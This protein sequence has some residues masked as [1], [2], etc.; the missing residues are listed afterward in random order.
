MSIW[1]SPVFYF[2]ILLMCVVV[3][4]LAAP[5]VVPW[6]NY[7]AD[8][9]SYG[10]KL[11]GRDVAIAGNIAVSLF[12]WPR[13]EAHHVAIGNPDGFSEDAF[14]QADVVRVSLSLGGLF[15]GTVNVE[16]VEV[17]RPQVNLQRNAAGNVN[18]ILVPQAK[19]TGEG[20][21][22]RVKLDQI[23][24][25]D[26][27]VSFDDLHNGRSMVFTDL[28]A[29]LSA[30]SVLGPWRMQGEAKWK[31][32][33]FELVVTTNAKEASSPL[34]FTVRLSPADTSLPLASVEG[35][36]D[37]AEF[38]GAARLDPQLATGEKSSVEGAF[39]PLAMQAAL[40]ASTDR[41]SLLKIRIAPSDRK[42]SGTLIEGDAIVEFGT[43]SH[44][45]VNLQSP[46]INMDTLV[47]STAMQQWRD[48]GFLKL[49]N[50]LLAR[51]PPTLVTDFSANVSVVTSGGQVLN[52]VRLTGTMQK[53][54][55]RVQQFA[56]QL[57]GRSLG[58]FDGVVF[59]G[60]DAAQL[61]GT[62]KFQSGDSRALLS[63]LDPDLKA[64]IEQHWKGS[65]G[66]LD[67]QSGRLD[68]SA[69]RFGISDVLYAF[70]GS[71][72]KAA[73]SSSFGAAPVLAVTIDAGQV[74]IDSLVTNGWSLTRDGGLQSILNF[75][76]QDWNAGT[77]ERRV[78]V[79]AE[80]LLLNGV[81]AQQVAIN[82]VSKASGFEISSLDI[83]NVNGAKL[84]GE[85]QMLDKGNGPEGTLNFQLDAQ[86]PRGFLQL[87]GFNHRAGK[88][89]QALGATHVNAKL[90]AGPGNNGPE[91]GLTLRGSS[92][93]L[94]AEIV[95]NARQ[96]EKGRNATVAV[97]GGLNSADS[98]AIARL[99]GVVP[100]AAAGPGDV[101]FEFNGSLDQGFLG[102]TK[103]KALDVVADFSGTM[104][105][106]QPYFGVTGRI[107]AQ[108]QDGRAFVAAV[109]APISTAPQQPLD[110]SA[111]VSVKD[112]ALSFL[113]LTGHIAGHRF[114]GVAGA[115]AEG[116]LQADL[117]TDLLDARE[118]M[119]LAFL[120]WE[121]PVTELAQGFA[122]SDEEGPSGDIFIKP[123]QFETFTSTA[124]TEV[125][126]AIGFE[127]A[128][129]QLSITAAGEQALKFDAALT[130]LGS[131][132]EFSGTLRWPFDLSRLL[133]T[134][135]GA[136]LVKGNVIAEGDFKSTGS[137]PSAALAAAEGKGHFWLSDAALSRLTLEGYA[138]AVLAAKTPEA[139]SQAFAKLGAGPGSHIGQRIGNYMITNGAVE[140]SAIPTTA[141]G[142]T[143]TI[144]PQ[145]DLTSGQIKIA[146]AL[147]LSAQPELPAVNIT[148]SGTTGNMELRN[149]T[150][151][152]A[153]KLGYDLLSKE[154][155]NLE[156]LQ[157]EQQALAAKEDAQ[158]KDDEQRFA[159]YQATKAE[160]RQQTRIRRFQ[161]A[162]QEK[163]TAALQ[164][165]SDAAIKSGAATSKI[166]LLRHARRLEIRRSVLAAPRQP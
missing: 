15:S 118:A 16:S 7:R 30:Q 92:G 49:T 46:R 35:A 154:M 107:S 158:R 53:E 47:G 51:L 109:G 148:Y 139:L 2:G 32:R 96:L 80:S 5:F 152:L 44:A 104:D 141:E 77:I 100:A 68:W 82:L 126:V 165:M 29:R 64:G 12:P 13:L 131:G 65:R 18:W 113:D 24:L 36:W 88:W 116:R 81:T 37:G 147:S 76:A 162:E 110:M 25:S 38:K 33:P 91:L 3:A 8:L 123:L 101:T 50:Q 130:P 153:A 4:A 129:R 95:L 155:A 78:N 14:V 85:G 89:T 156:Q 149:G 28:N 84:H 142:V 127:K 103:V 63:W 164:A 93:T 22:A 66:R 41:I 67:I 56:A 79:K 97:S 31:D 45:R 122:A 135:D 112:G 143:G 99:F 19:V 26:G 17:E 21:L 134:K 121:G 98:A 146:T 57:P 115:T 43:Q 72:G 133:M 27:L 6:N 48:G 55:I 73:V 54:A 94:N 124:L 58:V 102:S 39:K 86:D 52:D 87:A 160:L 20:L 105:V 62:F 111:V 151:A 34:K 132:H 125:V 90:S 144:V 61:G 106:K 108:S 60:K 1:R 163:R 140:F 136:A 83:G 128:K 10:R 69:E 114:A 40:A 75:M 157:Q 74:D 137:S 138:S 70:D 71:P 11:T 117:E 119:A 42:D 161:A 166:E 120:P 23:V 59:P 9:E 159:D 150:S 145:L